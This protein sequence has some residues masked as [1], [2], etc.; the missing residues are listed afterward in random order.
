MDPDNVYAESTPEEGQIRTRQTSHVTNTLDL[1]AQWSC[2]SRPPPPIESIREIHIYDFDN[3]LFKT[4]MPNRALW[5]DRV[6]G[7]LHNPDLFLAGG[8]WH[9]PSILEATGSGM[10]IE[11]KR[12][13]DGWWNEKVVDLAR[14]SIDQEDVLAILLTGRHEA[15]F[16]DIIRR[17]AKSKSLDF[18]MVC[19]KKDEGPAGEIFRTTMAYKQMLINDTL[20]TYLDATEVR[21]YEDRKKHAEN[22]KVF[23][24]NYN[25]KI[26]SLAGSESGQ[27]KR[28]KSIT[29]TVVMVVDSSSA[30]EPAT[31]AA[32]IQK[33][34]N[35][36]NRKLIE[37]DEEG[38][39]LPMSA[40]GRGKV[41][42]WRLDKQVTMTYYAIS[43]T[44]SVALA[45]ALVPQTISRTEPSGGKLN[46]LGNRIV[47]SFGAMEPDKLKQAGGLGHAVKFTVAEVG[48]LE[49]DATSKGEPGPAKMWAARVAPADPTQSIW[50]APQSFAR[51]Q[52][53]NHG[54]VILAVRGP[55]NRLGEVRRIRNWVPLNGGNITFDGVLKEGLRLDLQE[56][57]ILGEGEGD[58]HG[59][60]DGGKRKFSNVSPHFTRQGLNEN[61]PPRQPWR[62]RG[63]PFEGGATRG[64][65]RGHHNGDWQS[66][67]GS[68]QRDYS[69]SRGGRGRGGRG[70][71]GRGRGAPYR[72][73]GGGYQDLDAV[74]N[75]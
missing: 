9:N 29:H 4:P 69:P 49:G 25:A 50:I 72:G 45:K 74:P 64:G 7:F 52:A 67:L 8:W 26:F 11:E 15:R 60:S 13:W 20:E 32:L 5:S 17:I 41:K 1:L 22:F 21:I 61:D 53:K 71:G 58:V 38:Q 43:P 19:L 24:D 70:R 62:G 59:E 73:P 30:L 39:V 65:Y 66:S 27:L 75:F 36:H 31:E 48:F 54:T 46:I 55:V 56:I 16:A 35:E 23:L 47:V 42:G 3:T 40:V 18:D 51:G 68:V 34:V 57:D 44:D 2:S 63:R 14:I 37:L 10:E 6:Q 33:M 28:T 12:A